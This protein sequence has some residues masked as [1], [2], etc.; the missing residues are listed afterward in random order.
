MSVFSTP[1]QLEQIRIILSS[2]LRLPFSGET[3]PGAV[4]EAVL[5]YARDATTL[6]T[7]D[8]VDVIKRDA[9]CGWQV[10]A[11]KA[12][13]PVTWKRAKIPNATSLIRASRRSASGLQ[14]LGNAIIE[15]CNIHARQSLIAYDLD[16]IGYSRLIIHE[17]GH[18]T[19][20]ERLLC[21]RKNPDLFNPRDFKWKWSRPKRTIKKEQLS[22][23]HGI[24]VPTGKKWWAWHGLGENQLHFSGEVAWWPKKG[25]GHVAMF[26]LPTDRE[27]ISF[28]N[29]ME[30][31][32]R[33]DMPT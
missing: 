28:E 13:T 4:M 21:T 5:A 22:A 6:H 9:R 2:Y 11:T 14:D 7:Y 10:K 31:L 19:Y 32:S 12:A 1:Q 30:F 18:V 24:H 23:L 8:F 25:N 27:K 16:E 20:F 15:F 17:D 33:L 3:I 29:L 26:R